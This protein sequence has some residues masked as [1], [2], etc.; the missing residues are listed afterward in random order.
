MKSSTLGNRAVEHCVRDRLASWKF[1]DPPAGTVAEVNY[2]F[3]FRAE[4]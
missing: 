4:N 2:P 1:P 3:Y